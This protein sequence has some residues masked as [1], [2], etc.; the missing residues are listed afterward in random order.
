[1]GSLSHY[2]FFIY[3]TLKNPNIRVYLQKIISTQTVRSVSSGFGA[4]ASRLQGEKKILT[5]SILR[6]L[7]GKKRIKKEPKEPLGLL[8]PCD[9]GKKCV[10]GG[11]RQPTN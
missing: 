5:R 4:E 2:P 6:G 1:M 7:N 9:V 3:L 8:S 10:G 11:A